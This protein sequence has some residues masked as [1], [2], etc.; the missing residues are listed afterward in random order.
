MGLPF[1]NSRSRKLDQIVAIDLGGRVT[2]AVHLLRKGEKLHLASFAVL[3]TPASDKALS[4]EALAEHLKAVCRAMG[5]SRSRQVTLAI[6]VNETLFRQVEA[7]LMPVADLRQ[8]LKLNAK[9]YLQQDLPNYVFDCFFIPP[10][11]PNLTKLP[12]G[13]KPGTATPRNRVMVGGIRRDLLE[14]LQAAIR[15]AGLIADQVIPG[16]VGPSNAFEH[17]EPDLF[18]SEPVALVDVGF[19]NSTITI[20]DGGEIALNRVV[21]IGGDR[22]T[23][24]LMETLKITYL[25]A[26][27]IK[28]GMPTEVQV[29]LEPLI[30][31][32]GREL[33]A[34]L[35]FFEHQHDKTIGHVFVSG[36]TARSEFIL[37][38]LQNELMVQCQGWNPAKNLELLLTPEQRGTFESIAPQ[39]TVAIGAA[40]AAL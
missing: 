40:T 38:A 4:S 15:G 28:L 31:P 35:D 18:R 5:G 7:P 30:Q 37:Q 2:K 3:D 25:E 27:N 29:E 11:N 24:G 12:E 13:S 26:E 33:R 19:K 14:T 6:G 16:V 17:A 8:M 9:V 21:A 36:G 20:L 10:R 1:F 34:S 32:L 39:L 23:S 22:L